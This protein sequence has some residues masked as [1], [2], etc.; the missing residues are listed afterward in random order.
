MQKTVARDKI[1]EWRNQLQ[2]HNFLISLFVARKAC[3]TAC[4]QFCL[5]FK[6]EGGE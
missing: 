2:K 5:P 3:S 6:R 1:K 4:Q